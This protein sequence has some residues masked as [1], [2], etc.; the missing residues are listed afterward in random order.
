MAELEA[1]KA[2]HTAWMR[3]NNIATLKDLESCLRDAHA[4]CATL[5]ESAKQDHAPEP[6]RSYLACRGEQAPQH[7]LEDLRSEWEVVQEF[8]AILGPDYPLSSC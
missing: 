7:C 3:A 6:L 2:R 4:Q 8:V 1:L 5:I